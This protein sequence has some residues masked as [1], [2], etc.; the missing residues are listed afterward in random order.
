MSLPQHLPG[1]GAAH[2]SAG[3]SLIL[4]DGQIGQ[5]SKPK[6]KFLTQKPSTHPKKRTAAYRPL[7]LARLFGAFRRRRALGRR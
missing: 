6:V 4:P 3:K 2:R 1:W 7:T 5:E